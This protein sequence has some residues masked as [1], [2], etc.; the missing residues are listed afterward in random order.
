VLQKEGEEQDKTQDQEIENR[1]SIKN[2]NRKQ[3]TQKTN[4]EKLHMEKKNIQVYP[5]TVYNSHRR[6]QVS[7]YPAGQP[8]CPGAT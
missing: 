4:T 5:S 2:I 1:K 7:F 8:Q 3:K 6:Q